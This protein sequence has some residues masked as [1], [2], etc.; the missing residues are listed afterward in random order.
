MVSGK[1]EKTCLH[2]RCGLESTLMKLLID[3]S[4]VRRITEE[5]FTNSP[6]ERALSSH[7]AEGSGFVL[8]WPALIELLGF[9]DLAK[10][11]P[12][13]TDADPLYQEMITALESKTHPEYLEHLFDQVFV[14]CLNW[15]R[16]MPEI[17][18][19]FLGDVIR[20]RRG[21][22]VSTFFSKSL[23]HYEKLFLDHPY[24]TIHDLTLYLAWDRVCVDLAIVFEYPSTSDHVLQGLALLR[25]CLIESFQHITAQKK[26]VPGFF[27]MVEALY[28]YQMRQERLQTYSDADWQT[29]CESSQSLRPRDQFVDIPYVDAALFDSKNS[30][31]LP[32]SAKAL[33][34]NSWDQVSKSAALARYMIDVLKSEDV[35][36][37]QDLQAIE[38]ICLS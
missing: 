30:A 24:Q 32:L 17:H 26:T 8:S 21:A 14:K 16:S 5:H 20:E 9:G 29:L 13:F 38:I 3:R 2:R 36:W 27:R 28:A 4:V 25:E 22:A 33:T 18:P 10:G 6:F 15:V 7:L 12:S 11:F 1:A 37:H 31:N 35:D 23:D 34:M 19:T